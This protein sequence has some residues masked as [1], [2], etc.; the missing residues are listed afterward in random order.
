M[1][2]GAGFQPHE[3]R[4]WVAQRF[5]RCDQATLLPTGFSRWGALSIIFYFVITPQAI[6]S[7]EFPDGSVL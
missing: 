5:Q 1:K 2:A 6:R 3:S 7:P 4:F